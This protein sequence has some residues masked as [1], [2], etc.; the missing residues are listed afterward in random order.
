MTMEAVIVKDAKLNDSARLNYM[1]YG[2]L[3]LMWSGSF[4]N[5]KVVVDVM[6]PIFCAMMRVLISIIGLAVVFTVTRKP[7]LGRSHGMWRVWI[8]G[9][10]SQAIPFALLF[11]GERFVA[12]A[13]AGIINSTVSLWALLIGTV[14]FRDV[15]QWTPIKLCGL[16]LGFVGIVIIFY[17]SIHNGESDIIGVSAIMLMAI[18]YAVG[19][20]INQHVIF[21][22]MKISF[23][24]NLF[25]QHISSVLTLAMASL[26]LETWPPMSSV[27]DSNVIFSF[28]YLGLVA[29]TC[30]WMIF[31]YL[32]R[33]WGAVRTSSVMYIV[34]LLAIV[35]DLLFLHITPSGSELIGAAAIL[36]GVV[37]I[38]WTR[39]QKLNT[40]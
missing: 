24:A 37:L 30:A 9:L 16:M 31:F 34:P 4:I 40:L 5:I 12:P 25:H 38:Q 11:Y 21:P 8:A 10:A 35:W 18:S 29:T 26:M 39:K 20:L 15:S 33:E 27:F 32:I 36:V 3:A 2:L 22:K 23:E 28:L 14:A 17:P 6:P 13:L 19:G 1:L 7:F